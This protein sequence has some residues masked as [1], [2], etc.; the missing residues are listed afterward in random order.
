MQL[1]ADA[2]PDPTLEFDADP[3]IHNTA[4]EN[5]LLF[6]NVDKKKIGICK[7]LLCIIQVPVPYTPTL[8]RIQQ[9]V[10][11]INMYVQTPGG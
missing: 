9:T 1:S 5:E 3:G 2:D 11:S 4:S 6:F 10:S 8:I 7:K